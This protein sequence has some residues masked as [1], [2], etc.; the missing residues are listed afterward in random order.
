MSAPCAR[1]NIPSG[2]VTTVSLP[3]MYSDAAS[4]NVALS[5]SDPLRILM[6]LRAAD[7]C[8]TPNGRLHGICLV[9]GPELGPKPATNKTLKS[10][11]HVP[12]ISTQIP[13]G[14]SSSRAQARQLPVVSHTGLSTEQAVASR[15]PTQVPVAVWQNGVPGRPAQWSSS[16]Q[17]A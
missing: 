3:S 11:A 8:D 16:W 2:P 5:A 7:T 6:R 9:Q 14:H 17:A 1:P 15:Q 4:V 12:S 13:P 10:A